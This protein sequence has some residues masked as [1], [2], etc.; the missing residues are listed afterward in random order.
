MERQSCSRNEK[1]SSRYGRTPGTYKITQLC[2]TLED[3]H[4]RVP[5]LRETHDARHVRRDE[6][7]ARIPMAKWNV[8]DP[9]HGPTWH[10]RSS[11]GNREVEDQLLLLVAKRFA[12][13]GH[14]D[15][16]RHFH[17]ARPAMTPGWSA[18]RKL[19][20][21]WRNIAITLIEG[22]PAPPGQ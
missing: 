18:N 14:R 12:W 22:R 3:I 21:G 5:E 16:V 4:R 19:S 2:Q 15:R 20:G 6:S 17:S 9:W 11:W 1:R 7:A 8:D 10:N 13:R